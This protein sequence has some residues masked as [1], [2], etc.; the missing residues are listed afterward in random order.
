MMIMMIPR[1]IL[2]HLLIQ[3]KKRAGAVK[4]GVNDD[5]AADIY[6]ELQETKKNKKKKSKQEQTQEKKK[7]QREQQS[8]T[9]SERDDDDDEKKHKKKSAESLSLLAASQ[10]RKKDARDLMGD[11]PVGLLPSSAGG[12]SGMTGASLSDLIA[13]ASSEAPAASAGGYLDHDAYDKQHQKNNN[14]KKGGE[15]VSGATI[16]RLEGIVSKEHQLF[17]PAPEPDEKDRADRSA[18][19][20]VVEQDMVKWQAFL[21]KQKHARTLE[22]PLK[23]PDSS[24]V[25]ITLGGI[26]TSISVNQ[27]EQKL[28]EGA[29]NRAGGEDESAASEHIVPSACTPRV[30]VAANVCSR[31]NDLLIASGLGTSRAHKVLSVSDDDTGVKVAQERGILKNEKKN[32]FI[33]L[34]ADEDD[35]EKDGGT[36]GAFSAGGHAG[37]KQRSQKPSPEDMKYIRKLKSLIG[38]DIAKRKRFNK[39]K[40][41][42]YRRILRKEK[43]R[44]QSNK[45]RALE[46]INPE[47]Y[48][49]R[50]EEKMLKARAEERITQKHKNTSQWVKHVKKYAKFDGATREAI[51]AQNAEYARRLAKVTGDTADAELEQ[52]IRDNNADES[53]DEVERQVDAL[54]ASNSSARNVPNA[55]V[56]KSLLYTNTG[57]DDDED[58]DDDEDVK[59]RRKA[60][61]ELEGMAFMQRARAR[62]STEQQR[63]VEELTVDIKRASQG[64]PPLHKNSSLYAERSV[65][66]R[67]GDREDDAKGADDDLDWR[68]SFLTKEAREKSKAADALKKK[69]EAHQKIEQQSTDT[70]RKR[71]MVNPFSSLSSGEKGVAT[72]NAMI[73]PAEM[74]KVTTVIPAKGGI[75]A[76]SKEEKEALKQANKK[77]IREE[78]EKKANGLVQQEINAADTL[79]MANRSPKE[80]DERAP[81]GKENAHHQMTTLSSLTFSAAENKESDTHDHYDDHNSSSNTVAGTAARS[82]IIQSSSPSSSAVATT[83]CREEMDDERQQILVAQAF[84]GDDIDE[85]FLQQ[86]RAQVEH[87]MPNIDANASLPGWGEWG[88]A[89]EK[90]NKRHQAHVAKQEHVRKIERTM[91][92]QARVDAK[93]NHVI[94]NDDALNAPSPSD[95]PFVPRP[96]NSIQDYKGSLRHPRGPEHNTATSFIVQ[97]QPRTRTKPGEIIDP[98]DLSTSTTSARKKPATSMQK[99][100][101]IGGNSK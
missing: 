51:A 11:A 47:A 82:S 49:K 21:K 37:K 6:S 24:A 26:A 73:Q 76:L 3:G 45:D 88:G 12:V 93:L 100:R 38:Y 32:E 2:P 28:K 92:M 80:N 18:T 98:V 87:L 23:R 52:H 9:L 35:D 101:R 15:G 86:K 40:S 5:D 33:S 41:K 36:G 53:E 78:D 17:A 94:I 57:V 29:A 83:G 14:T 13:S 96:F 89:S 95:T 20:E 58:D 46:L 50:I 30:K 69:M 48:R 84:A 4:D 62:Q 22:F 16:G 85:D 1:L 39:I 56:S 75:Q 65:D 25:P 54:F 71:F 8:T 59:K 61:K 43:S 66:G 97:N 42:V 79:M 64:L 91:L 19:R 77:R 7:Q 60:K 44:A 10:R 31:L 70:G 55:D 67:D 72:A 68:T 34:D 74:E 99:K 27:A 90:L 81:N 63:A